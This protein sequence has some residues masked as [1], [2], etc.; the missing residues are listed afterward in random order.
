[1]RTALE[2]VTDAILRKGLRLSSNGRK[3]QCPSH[4]DSNPSLAIDPAEKYHGVVLKCHAGCATEDVVSAIGLSMADL[5]DEPPAKAAGRV[6]VARYPYTDAAGTVLF[7]KIRYVPKTFIITPPG[8]VKKL[9]EKPLYRLPELP[10][11]IEAG[12]VVHLVEGEKDADRLRSKGYT[13]TCNFDG[14]GKFNKPEYAEYLRGATVVIIADNDDAGHRHADQAKALLARAGIAVTVKIPAEGKDVSDHLDAG[15]GMDD[16]QPYPGPRAYEPKPGTELVDHR[17]E[18]GNGLKLRTA[19][20]LELPPPTQWLGLGWLPRSAI[21][22]MVG[23]EGIGKSLLWVH[24]A[25]YITTGKPFAPFGIPAREPADVVVIVT[26]DSASEVMSRLKLAGA[27]LNRIIFF[28]AENDGTGTPVFGSGFQGDMLLLDALLNERETK[29][30]MLVVD[31]WLDTVA[32]NLIIRDTQQARAALDPWKQLATRHNLAALLVT[33]TNRTESTNIRDLMGGTAVLRQKA[34]MVLFAARPKSDHD[35]PVQHL[36]VGP[37]KSNVTG[38]VDAVK[39]N[40]TVEQVRAR[41]NDDPGT[42]A[43][44]TAPA[45]ALMTIRNLLVQWKQEELEANRKPTKAE[46]CQEAIRDYLLEGDGQCRTRDLKEHLQQIGYGKTVAEMAMSTV[47]ESVRN[48]EFG[49]EFTYRLKG[50]QPS[51]EEPVPQELGDVRKVATYGSATPTLPNV[52][53]LPASYLDGPEIRKQGSENAVQAGD[54][55]SSCHSG[56]LTDANASKG[57]SLCNQCLFEEASH[58]GLPRRTPQLN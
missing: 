13:A 23:E 45:S 21:T 58:T 8:A 26:E 54:P 55:C 52:P 32:G 47:G 11:A 29:P 6:E 46:E 7:E 35:S 36:W 1:M 27:D 4:D 57:I 20:D 2:V 44:L 28:A 3:A 53:I 41:T 22:V 17:G 49:G 48:A 15:L 34:R 51:Y 31:A 37:D 42:T 24:M 39:F 50:S 9:A 38:L 40:V 25:A 30:A 16:L 43:H 14:A 19:T 18:P 12:K 5:F 10:A 33:H 56:R